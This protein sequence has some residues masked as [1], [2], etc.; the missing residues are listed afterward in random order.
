[1]APLRSVLLFFGE[2]VTSLSFNPVKTLESVFKPI[3]NPMIFKVLKPLREA[4]KLPGILIKKFQ[5][6][7]NSFVNSKETS[8]KNYVSIG[9]YYV[10]KRLLLIV[11]LV[12]ILIVYFLFIKPPAFVNKWFNRVPVVV[13]NTPKAAAFS[14]DA[15]IVSTDKKQS[16]YVGGLKDGL[17]M[18]PGKLYNETGTLL[19]E[20]EF[21]KGMKNG[22]GSL[23]DDSG[24]LVYKGQFTVDH[25]NGEGT[26]FQ[27]DRKIRYTGQFQNGKFGGPGKLYN[28]SGAL[29]YEG[30][31]LEG[32]YHGQ[33][34]LFSQ[35]GQIVY[36]GEFAANEYNGAGKKYDE[37]GKLL[38]EGAFKAGRYAGEGTEYYPNG[39]VKYKGP[40][41]AGSYSGVGEMSDDKGILRF[42]GSFQ[43]GVMAG[44]GEAYD[45]AGK[46]VYKGDFAAGLYDGIGSLY[47]K[48]GGIVLK[49]FFEKGRVSLQKF[50]GLPSKK[51]EDLLGKPAEV[52]LLDQPQPLSADLQDTTD[53]SP[54]ANTG[55]PANTTGPNGPSADSGAA[56]GM[57]FQMNYSDLQ[58][59]FLVEPSKTNPKEAVVT[60]MK[61]WGS[62][63][64]S[65]LQPAIET[66]K[67]SEKT[68]AEGFTVLEL[69]APFPGGLSIN[70]YYRDENLYSL[71]FF[72]GEKVAHEL[73]IIAIERIKP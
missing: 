73:E 29:I 16:R 13:E 31:F 20:G 60:E 28:D 14:G 43:N 2:D 54:A 61:I 59:S 47:D 3:F 27:K 15:K 23:Y 68:N 56:A 12:I 10:S 7:V 58:Y 24:K 26:L 5:A 53:P 67:D 66:F 39:F 4:T 42:K 72:A 19:Y 18:G 44:P 1:L 57:K 50:I 37:Q 46:L 34:K 17:Y 51:L 32:M 65:V 38:Y 11:T 63:P 8:L 33:G 49:S 70:R 35:N 30:A 69:Q 9:A 6:L 41:V 21:D 25:Y 40:F 36:E 64:L 22:A 45:E 62:K 48:D 71:T 52:A 55:A